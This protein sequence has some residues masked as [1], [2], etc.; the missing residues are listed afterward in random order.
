MVRICG[1]H[2][3]VEAMRHGMSPEEACKEAVRRV[4]KKKG[5]KA[6]DVQVAFLAINNKG[7]HGGFGSQ[8]GFTYCVTTKEGTKVV[9]AKSW[10]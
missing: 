1:S 10:F 8:K 9:T 6:K 7:Q 3:V 2:T 4:V 5:A